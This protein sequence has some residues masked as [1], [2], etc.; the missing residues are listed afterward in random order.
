M[1]FI[2]GLPQSGT[3]NAILVVIDKFSKFSHFIPLRHPFTATS[4]AKLFLDH[5]YRLHGLPQVIV[6]D[7]D[8][9]FTSHFWQQLF[10]LVGVDLW[11]STAYHPQTDGQTERLNQCLETYLRCFVHACP[12]KW[13]S[14]HPL[15]EY[16][17]NTSF[18]SAL[19]H[20]PF[21]VLYGYEPRHLG[22]S[23]ESTDTPVLALSEWLSERAIMQEVV[24]QHL[25]QAQQRMKCQA[26]KSRSE[27]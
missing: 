8:R 1:D 2:E 5:V 4:V 16:W 12:T 24:R 22:L 25:L 13:I 11:M 26:D 18:H 21:T 19:G 15:A 17:Y 10:K 23:I 14:W 9:I 27:H 20:T 6:T 7:R 3:A